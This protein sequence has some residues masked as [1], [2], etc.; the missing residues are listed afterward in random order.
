MNLKRRQGNAMNNGSNSSMR[1]AGCLACL[2]FLLLPITGAAQQR[3]PIRIEQVRVGYPRVGQEH[4]FKAGA[5]TPVYVDVKAWSGRRPQPGETPLPAVPRGDIIVESVDSDDV[6]NRFTMSLP[7]LDGDQQFTLLTYTKPGSSAPEIT[8]NAEIDGRTV[9]THRETYVSIDLGHQLY[10]AVGSRLPVLR[11]ALKGA[12]NPTQGDVEGDDISGKET[13]PRHLDVIEDVRTLPNRWF[14]FEPVDLMI[15]TTGNRDFLT[16]LLNEREQRKEALVEWVRRGGRLVVSVGRNQDMVAKLEPIQSALPVSITGTVQLSRLSSLKSFSKADRSLESTRQQPLEV[17][18]L[19]R[20]AGREIDVVLAEA[21]G[22]PL[23]VSGA[24]GLGQVTVVAFDLDGPPF[25]TWTP[26]GQRGFWNALK[27]KTAPIHRAET[28][29]QP[30]VFSQQQDN[31]DV[32]SQLEMNLEE[33]E[34]VPVI[35]F[36]WVALFIL[37][38]ILV[39]GPLDYFFLKKVV[40][41]LE[42]TWITFPTV[43]ITISV[44][45][46]FTA[47]WLKGNDQKINKIDLV[48]ID[49]HTKQ[50]YGNTWFTIFSPRIQHYTI[51]AE[52]GDGGWLSA[53]EGAAKPPA[54]SFVFSWMGRPDAGFRG[55]N[56]A[57]SQGLFRRA[58]DYAPEATGLVGVPIQV[59]STKSLQGAWQASLNAR[60]PLVSA[61]LRHVVGNRDAFP[62]GTIT[63]RLPVPLVDAYLHYNTG[64]RGKWYSMGRLEPGVPARID[65]LQGGD[66]TS[67]WVQRVAQVSTPLQPGRRPTPSTNQAA[68]T[69]IKRISFFQAAA[70]SGRDN[71]LYHLDQ[72]W[73]LGNK[74]EV[75]VFGRVARIEDEA[76]GVAS[77]KASP[78][79]LWLG[80]LPGAG[81][82]RQKL[83]GKMSQETFVRIIIPVT[84]P[85]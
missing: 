32:A 68:N 70:I 29:H 75:I 19:E 47:Y 23:I 46:Y 39:V 7:A 18:K 21:N 82:P 28:T 61:D 48:D 63:S 34:D 14:A 59:W 62:S 54:S 2:S 49:L 44:V 43:V 55:S 16:S 38:Y 78:T 45:A 67:Q 11:Q 37:A 52:P 66:D 26:T 65:N 81:Q 60:Q 27:D 1:L 30:Q 76:E 33:F 8:V 40:K 36:G 79:K 22:Q 6:R 74:D 25:T 85:N 50:L 4:E 64:G 41:R 12:A 42:L 80:A 69:I 5:W 58:Y 24:Y 17:A 57:R 15:V 20:K 73:R 72:S 71:A 53:P 51:G 3:E 77:D 10:L 56:R 35:S 31:D 84:T 9:S 83:V 13:G